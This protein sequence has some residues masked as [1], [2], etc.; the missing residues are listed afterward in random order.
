MNNNNFLILLASICVLALGACSD[1]SRERAE[2]TGSALASQD[3]ILRYVPADAPYVMAA[4]EPLPH[5]VRDEL[6]EKATPVIEAYRKL[7]KV[8]LQLETD[9][10]AQS[11]SGD[12]EAREFDALL[13]EM[14]NLMTPDGLE[15]AG[16][17]RN[18]TA[19][20]Y[21]NGLLPV[22]RVSLSDED[23]M[24]ST[25]SRLEEQA[26]KQMPVASIDGHSYRIADGEDGTALIVAVLD[27]Y[28]VVSVVPNSPSD[29]VLKSALGLELP[30]TSIAE[31]GELGKLAEEYGFQAYALGFL[32]VE[33]IASV[34]LD[35]PT[36]VN[37][38]M[39][40]LLGYDGSTVSDVCRQEVRALAGVA[41]R[42]VAGYTRINAGELVAN[43]VV[44]L[45][46]DIANGLAALTAP[47][48]GLGQKNQ[49]GLMS[50]GMS[51]N[52]LAARE[53]Y[54]ARLDALDAKPYQCE[55]FAGMQE[56]VAGGR[57]MLNQPMFPIVYSFRGFLASIDSVKGMDIQ[58]GQPPTDVDMRLLIATDNA[59]GLIA[60]AAMFSPE[61]A[62]LELQPDGKPVR[63]P[64]PP[65]APQVQ[66]AWIAMSD[67][68]LALS[69]GEG[70]ET[71]LPGMLSAP[72]A[73]PPPFMSI[74][75]D[76]ASYYGFVG[77]A[78][79][80]GGSDANT[81]EVNAAVREAMTSLQALIRRITVDVQFTE[82]GIEFPSTVTLA[83]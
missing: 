46:S 54:E 58:A 68:A 15:S 9:E 43:S 41:P 82:R 42:I 35:D 81:P 61:V 66:T 47:V 71:Q 23:L 77:D 52:P 69:V 45:R 31:S 57:D 7:L 22:F 38:E 63:L 76:A 70:G 53:F 37:K 36:G 51:L 48:P 13:N 78:A 17:D 44:E 16:I 24:E 50:F 10:N 33:R 83:D 6:E 11:D 62:A 26:D 59:E 72:L 28:L 12:R 4:A 1:S 64:V 73:S 75:M 39:L 21:G 3:S 27:G 25:L 40:A 60:M 14:S 56:A 65:V 49:R 80:L 2:S 30:A 74:D 20:F 55:F 67:T 5:D 19:A 34:F 18:S 29:A 32:N 8:T 79:A